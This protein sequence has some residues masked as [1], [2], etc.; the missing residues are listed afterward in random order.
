MRRFFQI[1]WLFAA[2]VLP[3]HA[4]VV[5][6]IYGEWTEAEKG[7]WRIQVL[8]EAGYAVPDIRDDPA[9]SAPER[10]WLYAESEE[11]WAAMRIEA[12]R[13]LREALSIELDDGRRVEWK[14][15]FPDFEKRPPDFPALLNNGAYFRMN[16]TP[17]GA[18]NGPI[19]VTWQS[20]ERPTFILKMPGPDDTY[21]TL[22]PGDRRVIGK[23]VNKA[24]QA[25]SETRSAGWTSFVQGYHHVVPLGWDHVLFILGLF[26]YQRKWR[27]LLNQSLA[28]TA[29][30]TVT[31]GLAAAGIV[32]VTGHWVEPL[33][34]VSLVAIALEN[35][36]KK[37]QA[38]GRVRLLIVFAF[39]LVHG[40][41]FAG[42][43]SAWL[44]PGEGFLPSLLSANLGVEAAQITLLA[45]AWLL[46]LGWSETR[47]YRV[48][49][50]LSCLGIAAIG[51]VWAIERLI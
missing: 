41:G 28:F 24:G 25:S 20:G 48:I 39:G 34:A 5:A 45:G 19:T 31:L 4:H 29:A 17:V 3:L 21:L 50:L 15:D 40:L 47:T 26:F 35:L 14:V 44:K 1:A 37:S 6:Q 8:F 46:T 33:I 30:H 23:L 42:A 22:D 51:T 2:L 27:P 43:L 38:E 11:S 36:R 7:A 18:T 10:D 16:L 32:K 9:A 12:E 49:R 13:Y